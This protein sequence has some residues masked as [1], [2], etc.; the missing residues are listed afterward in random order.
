V[1]GARA[2]NFCPGSRGSSPLFVYFPLQV[3]EIFGAAGND[4]F[5]TKQAKERAEKTL[6]KLMQQKLSTVHEEHKI[7]NEQFFGL[8][9]VKS[10]LKKCKI[11]GSKKSEGARQGDSK[12]GRDR[13]LC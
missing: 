5:G 6:R 9:I 12:N 2:R 11:K 4:M 7:S 8:I 13:N 10:V 1:P 3:H